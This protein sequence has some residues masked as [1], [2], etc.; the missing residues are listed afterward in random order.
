VFAF[1]EG[2]AL[3]TRLHFKELPPH[4]IPRGEALARGSIEAGEQIDETFIG[5]VVERWR[6]A[7]MS[8]KLKVDE[9]YAEEPEDEIASIAAEEFGVVPQV[10]SMQDPYLTDE[11]RFGQALKTAAKLVEARVGTP[12]QSPEPPASTVPP[13]P[14]APAPSA[15]SGSMSPRLNELRER[16][17]ARSGL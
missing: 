2:V 10:P 6:G 7:T 8:Q 14:P 1:G 16:L 15:G 3:P 4:R 9:R 12:L 11:N 5:S 17:R 13:A